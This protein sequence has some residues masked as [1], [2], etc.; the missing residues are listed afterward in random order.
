MCSENAYKQNHLQFFLLRKCMQMFLAAFKRVHHVSVSPLRTSSASTMARTAPF[1]TLRSKSLWSS[2]R[3]INALMWFY[4][5][6]SIKS[7]FINLL[8][9]QALC[10]KLKCTRIIQWNMSIC[11]FCLWTRQCVH[12]VVTRLV[13]SCS[14]STTTSCT[15][16][17]NASFLLTG[18]WGCTSTGR[19]S[20]SN[21][22]EAVVDS[23]KTFMKHILK[24]FLFLLKWHFY[25]CLRY[26]SLTG[27]PSSQRALAFEK[28]SVL[29]NI[30]AL[31]TQIGARQDRSAT[32]GIDRAIDAF[33]RAA[34]TDRNTA[35]H[36]TPC[37]IIT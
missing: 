10:E 28:G 3:L 1:M 32:A 14:W 5:V 23:L 25:L 4:N 12:R 30:G 31:Y 36:T 20:S 27:V 18:T 34:G 22:D 16:W 6:F 17:I 33:Q 8:E 24:L 37:H 29:F 9:S 15:T 21:V 11:V 2:D 7:Y 13:W 19:T 26:D 35:S